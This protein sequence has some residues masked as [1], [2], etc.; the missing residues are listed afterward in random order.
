MCDGWGTICGVL[1]HYGDRAANRSPVYVSLDALLQESVLLFCFV[2]FVLQ[3]RELSGS[4]MPQWASAT[5]AGPF[6]SWDSET[7]RNLVAALPLRPSRTADADG[8]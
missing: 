7:L 2:L 6:S 4:V 8:L 3:V 1:H 5:T